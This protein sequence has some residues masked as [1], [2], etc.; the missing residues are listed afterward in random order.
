VF[1][2]FVLTR[3]CCDSLL[4]LEVGNWRE[5]RQ[6]RQAFFFQLQLVIYYVFVMLIDNDTSVPV[7]HALSY[8]FKKLQC[9]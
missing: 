5:E 7:V 6:R 2:C 8:G 4:A 9:N 3:N 1:L